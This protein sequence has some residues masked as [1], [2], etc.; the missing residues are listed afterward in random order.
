VRVTTPVAGV[1][2]LDEAYFPGWRLEE[3]GATRGAIRVDH[4]FL[5]FPLTAGG[6]DLVIRYAPVSFTI[7]AGVSIAAA[8]L[9]ALLAL[10]SPK[11][12]PTPA[13]AS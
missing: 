2:V 8:V 9:L 4:A 1:L 6:H 7:G 5:G 10:F 3:A 11:T 12:K 13:I